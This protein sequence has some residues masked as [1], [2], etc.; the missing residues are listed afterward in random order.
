MK[1]RPRKKIFLRS[2]LSDANP[3]RRDVQLERFS[4]LHLETVAFCRFRF[5]AYAMISIF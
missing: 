3:L 2:E 4:P 1:T 5:A